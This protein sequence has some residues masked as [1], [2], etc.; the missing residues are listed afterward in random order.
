M[1]PDELVAFA[2]DHLEAIT[3]LNAG[4]GYRCA[5]RL[6]DGIYLP[7]VILQSRA[8]QVAFAKR[9]L[10]ETRPRRMGLVGPWRQSPG[11]SYEATI[12]VFT[13]GGNRVN[14]YDI[15]RVEPSPYALPAERL[16][17][18]EGETSMAWTQFV[19][20]MRDGREFSF[21]TTYS[22][23]FFHMPEGYSGNDVVRIIPHGKVDGPVYRER[24][25]F[26]C[27]VEGL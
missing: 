8:S 21:G 3:A 26:A 16:K 4:P 10:E 25:W 27:F 22:I 6:T 1:K 9:R 11:V 13:A 2:K 17:E 19:A 12:D 7:A 24:P 14:W 23:E 20:A 15:A 5:A 18:I